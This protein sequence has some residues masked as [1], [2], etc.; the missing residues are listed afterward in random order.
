MTP[1]AP[2]HEVLRA[3]LHLRT[4]RGHLKRCFGLGQLLAVGVGQH[5]VVPNA[6]ESG[7]QDVLHEATDEVWPAQAHHAKRGGWASCTS[8]RVSGLVQ[9]RR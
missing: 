5:P 3:F 6:F 2:R 1:I 7:R 9:R 8:H 4:G